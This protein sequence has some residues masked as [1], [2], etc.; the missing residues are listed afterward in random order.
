MKINLRSIRF[1]LCLWYVVFTLFCILSLSAFSYAYLGWA[2]SS[3]SE[4]TLLRRVDR[5]VRFMNYREDLYG[6][7]DFSDDVRR[8]ATAGPDEN[9][10]QIDSLDGRIIYPSS[11]SPVVLSWPKGDC[12]APC[13][14]MAIDGGHRIR[15]VTVRATLRHTPVL[16]HM[17]GI[18][19]EHNST[20]N[21]VFDSYLVFLPLLLIAAVAGGYGLSSRALVPV[22]RLTRAARRIG[23]H[24]LDRRLPVPDT[25]DELQDLAETCN[26]LLSRIQVA[27]ERLK[28]FT[29]DISHDLRTS[30]SIMLSAADL[31]LRRPR[32]VAEYQHTIQS[33][34][35]ECDAITA[36]LDD[37]FMAS[38]ADMGDQR[39]D[40]VPIDISAILTEVSSN[41]VPFAAIKSHTVITEIESGLIVNGDATTIRRLAHILIENAIKYTPPDGRITVRLCSAQDVVELEVS[42]TG[43]GIA[44]CDSQRIFERF[45]RVESSRNRDQGGSGLGL[46]IAKWIVD[47]HSAD[48]QIH[49]SLDKGSTFTVRFPQTCTYHSGT[50]SRNWANKVC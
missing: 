31:C 6:K 4:R 9:Y 41:S 26:E 10:V 42:D 27:V 7:D 19:D 2:L 45:Y 5:L 1:R 50:V 34:Q 13:F 33:V 35:A 29:S 30:I 12:R 46:A 21:I 17:G 37:L 25:H 44:P 28:Q 39:P 24:E 18:V 43:I 23:V 40:L 47:I 8:Y 32:T 49:S 14:G 22:A 38:R 15:M 11:A 36:L 48:I 16:V 20:L 3:T